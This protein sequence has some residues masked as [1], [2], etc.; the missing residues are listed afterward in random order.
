MNKFRFWAIF[1][2]VFNSVALITGIAY[3]LPLR[4][5]L[6]ALSIGTSLCSVI[7]LYSSA[8]ILKRNARGFKLAMRQVWFVAAHEAAAMFF[9]TNSGISLRAI[10]V[11]GALASAALLYKL[12]SSPAARQYSNHE[13]PMSLS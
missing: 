5:H 13:K 3:A 2:I 12:F 6:T 10:V 7:G 9:N 11:T 4:P 1:G 8:L